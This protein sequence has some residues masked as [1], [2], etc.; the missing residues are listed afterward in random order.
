MRE[1]LN[2]LE[3]VKGAK[4]I[5]LWSNFLCEY[6]EI[7]SVKSL[8]CPPE[9]AIYR[10]LSLEEFIVENLIECLIILKSILNAIKSG[11]KTS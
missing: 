7:L 6:I 2:E 10:D 1:L 5:F 11:R 8:R 3:T 4:R 9:N